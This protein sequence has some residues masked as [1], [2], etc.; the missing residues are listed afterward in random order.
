M[1][2]INNYLKGSCGSGF[3]CKL[4]IKDFSYIQRPFLITNNHV[5]NDDYLESQNKLFIEINGKD[6]ILDLI[7]RNKKL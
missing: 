4:N 3:F 2:K 6:K 1:C 5:I 7:N